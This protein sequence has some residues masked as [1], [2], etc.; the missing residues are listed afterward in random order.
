MYTDRRRPAT[1]RTHTHTCC[2]GPL[3]L[4][5]DVG[6]GLG[7]GGRHGSFEPLVIQLRSPRPSLAEMLT[8]DKGLR[9]EAALRHVLAWVPR[10]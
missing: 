1:V 6:P 8:G 5:P 3:R 10:F 7:G 2:I 4:V 9:D